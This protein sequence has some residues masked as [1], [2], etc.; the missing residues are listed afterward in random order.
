MRSPSN[1]FSTIGINQNKNTILV[2]PLSLSIYPHIHINFK[3]TPQTIIIIIYHSRPMKCSLCPSKPW[4][5]YIV[6]SYIQCYLKVYMQLQL[7]KLFSLSNTVLTIA[8]NKLRTSWVNCN[9]V[10]FSCC[11]C[12]TQSN[13]PLSSTST[14]N[15][16][17]GQTLELVNDEN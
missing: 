1:P 16:K 17:P 9:V 4:L 7:K 5:T 15:T 10:I 13:R 12:K 6:V 2:S 3:Q 8:P 11:L 14:V